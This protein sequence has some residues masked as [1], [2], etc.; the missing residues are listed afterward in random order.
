MMAHYTEKEARELLSAAVAKAPTAKAWAEQHGL[1]P[2]HL[3]DVL[4]GKRSVSAPFAA[5]LG[6][7]QERVYLRRQSQ[8]DVPEVLS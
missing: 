7:Y 3:S 5:A 1:K 6:L 2:R 8:E 4:L